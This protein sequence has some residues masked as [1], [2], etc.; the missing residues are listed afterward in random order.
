MVAARKSWFAWLVA[1]ALALLPLHGMASSPA[2]A[3]TPQGHCDTPQSPGQG[4]P[5]AAPDA[6]K[7]SICSHCAACHAVQEQTVAALELP[8]HVAAPAP[9][10]EPRLTGRS[11]P[12]EQHP[13]LA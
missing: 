13:P 6:G 1:L 4:D 5:D 3:A 8:G 7:G 10:S 11:P 2:D 9:G 12:P